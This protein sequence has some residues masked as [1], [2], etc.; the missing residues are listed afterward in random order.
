[1]DDDAK[2]VAEMFGIE[3]NK[4]S[5]LENYYFYCKRLIKGRKEPKSRFKKS[6]PPPK[7]Q[8]FAKEIIQRSRIYG[9]SPERILE[10]IDHRMKFVIEQEAMIL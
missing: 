1:V 3:K 7:R 5:D 2:M 10:Q 8:G 9:D 6:P 4:I